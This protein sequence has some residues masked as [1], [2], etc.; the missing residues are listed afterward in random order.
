LTAAG[1]PDVTKMFMGGA[2]EVPYLLNDMARD[3]VG[4]L[5]VLGIDKAH[6]VG[7]SMGGMIAQTMAINHADRV[8]TLTS[9]MSSTGEQGLPPPTPEALQILMSPTPLDWE[10]YAKRYVKTW[11]VLRAGSF[12]LD[13]ARDLAKAEA[14]F[15]RGLNPPGVARQLA[16]VLGSGSRVE[17]LRSVKA[18]TLVIHGDVDPLVNVAA[19]KATAA[20]IP[21]AKLTIVPGM[22]HAFPVSLWPPVIDAVAAHAK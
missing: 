15:R 17:A 2:V 9:I 8:R 6:L 10:S 3:A 20:A 14:M 22:G 19:G 7:A 1:V 12:P 21:G 4:L 11:T 18:P 5:D 13:E 16:A